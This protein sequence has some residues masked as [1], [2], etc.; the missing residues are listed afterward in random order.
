MG[1]SRRSSFSSR[2][3]PANSDP[4]SASL[5]R[6]SAITDPA[7]NL[8]LQGQF[9]STVWF[10]QRGNEFWAGNTPLYTLMLAAWLKVFGIS[11][12][13]VRSL[14]YVLM[15]VAMGLLWELTRREHWIRRPD[16]RLALCALLLTSRGMVFTYR[17][18]RYDVLGLVLFAAAA[19]VWT[20]QKGREEICS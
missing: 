2:D 12:L 11:V 4:L 13:V 8:V 6:R 14:N 5:D 16:L 20:G 3:Q 17:M 7:V 19:L 1:L 18:G 10:V 15:A 9:S